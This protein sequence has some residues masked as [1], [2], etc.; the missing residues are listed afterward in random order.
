MGFRQ[1]LMVESISK[2]WQVATKVQSKRS[3]EV[4][5]LHVQSAHLVRMVSLYFKSV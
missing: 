4:F 3:V 5:N 1:T 2:A